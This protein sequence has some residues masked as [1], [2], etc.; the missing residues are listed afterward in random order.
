MKRTDGRTDQLT[1]GPTD[2][3]M[4]FGDPWMHLRI[5]FSGGKK[6]CYGQTDQRTNGPTDGHTLL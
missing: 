2:R 6:M 3:Q 4:P 5:Q 1:N